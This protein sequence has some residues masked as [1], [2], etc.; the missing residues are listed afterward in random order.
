M[1]R[2]A[3][4]SKVSSQSFITVLL[5]AVVLVSLGFGTAVGSITAGDGTIGEEQGQLEST[6]ANTEGLSVS[7]TTID[8]E[9]IGVVRD[10]EQVT[11]NAT[12][13][14]RDGTPVDGESVTFRVG[15]ENATT[16]TVTDGTAQ[17]TFSPTI[18]LTAEQAGQSVAVDILEGSVENQDTVE[19][20]HETVDLDAG[21]NPVSVPQPAT[22]YTED[23]ATVSVWNSDTQTY[24]TLTN[25]VFD[26]PEQLNRGIYATGETATAE[27]GLVFS[28]QAPQPG[29]A[30]LDPGWNFVGSNFA[31]DNVEQGDTLLLEEDLPVDFSQ[32]TVFNGTLDVQL[33]NDTVISAYQSYWVFVESDGVDRPIINPSYDPENRSKVLDK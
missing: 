31:I 2:T 8:A 21:L 5:A 18:N 24:E 10:T 22:L 14:T 29:I 27:I 28:S 3:N 30:S 16:A 7:E 6:Q 23:V 12:G 15:G 32:V 13:I 4:K 11:V 19:V 26:S 33:E 9:I 17:A 1:K 25:R 20:V